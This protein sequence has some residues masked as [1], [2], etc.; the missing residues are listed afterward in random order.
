MRL[1]MTTITHHFKNLGELSSA[2]ANNDAYG[3]A[4]ARDEDGCCRIK[5]GNTSYLVDFKLRAVEKTARDESTSQGFWA[6]V[7]GLFTSCCG[8]RQTTINKIK[9]LLFKVGDHYTDP[10]VANWVYMEQMRRDGV[11]PATCVR[12]VKEP[13]HHYLTPFRFLGKGGIAS[14]Y[15]VM[16][17]RVAGPIMVRKTPSLAYVGNILAREAQLLSHLDHPNI[18]SCWPKLTDDGSLVMANGGVDLFALCD[19]FRQRWPRDM[20]FS[21]CRQLFEG[22]VYLHQHNVV[23]RDIKLENVLVDPNTEHLSL[24]DFG[25]AMDLGP[26]GTSRDFCGTYEFMAP[27]VFNRQPY[28]TSP[29]IFSAGCMMYTM[30]TDLMLRNSQE[31]NHGVYFNER[32][33]RQVLTDTMS[34]VPGFSHMECQELIE[35]L[36]RML[37]RDPAKRITAPEVLEILNKRFIGRQV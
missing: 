5:V 20:F 3:V 32:T 8:R 19:G 11:T 22:L 17:G 35:L 31:V 15:S 6:R 9:K 36:V 7:K 33:L 24:V 25:L 26:L 16:V 10:S 30:L 14:V 29:D 37:E 13:D 23:H 2:V 21:C 27:E 28:R 1:Y 4:M 34:F 18:I 12:D